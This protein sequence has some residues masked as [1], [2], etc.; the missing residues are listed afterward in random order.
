MNSA[1]ATNET[2]SVLIPVSSVNS[3]FA[4]LVSRF[5]RLYCSPREL[6]LLS[7][8]VEVEQDLLLPLHHYQ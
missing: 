2:L 6:P 8:I 7:T 3:R 1:R 4:L 5:A